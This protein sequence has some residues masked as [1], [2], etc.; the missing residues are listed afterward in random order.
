MST[1]DTDCTDSMGRR[2][3]ESRPCGRPCPNLWNHE[4]WLTIRE[5]REICGTTSAG[6]QSV[7]SV[8]PRALAHNP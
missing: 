6:S 8:E 3:V 1:D 2:E 5:I 7:K 4:R